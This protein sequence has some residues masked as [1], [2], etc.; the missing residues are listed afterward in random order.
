MKIRCI[1]ESRTAENDERS[2]FMTMFSQSA[3]SAKKLT[4]FVHGQNKFLAFAFNALTINGHSASYSNTVE[5]CFV[6]QCIAIS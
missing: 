6:L 3:T 2:R 1:F 5:I 4:I